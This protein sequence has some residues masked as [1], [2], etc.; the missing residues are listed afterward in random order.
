MSSAVP[1]KIP[2]IL[3][4]ITTVC[5]CSSLKFT[6]WRTVQIGN[7]PLFCFRTCQVSSECHPLIHKHTHT[8]TFIHT[9]THIHTHLEHSGEQLDVEQLCE[10]ATP[11]GKISRSLSDS[12]TAQGQEEGDLTH[13]RK[14]VC[15]QKEWKERE[16]ERGRERTCNCECLCNTVIPS[17]VQLVE[18]HLRAGC[19]ST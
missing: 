6:G 12:H 2:M 18:F 7:I 8:H 17:W 13:R 16:R 4:S 3:F 1:L 9:H 14:C 10:V 19:S 5:Q 11:H 15:L